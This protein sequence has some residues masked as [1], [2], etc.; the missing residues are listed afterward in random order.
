M[1]QFFRCPSSA[2]KCPPTGSPGTGAGQSRAGQANAPTPR[3]W[4]ESHTF[5]VD[6]GWYFDNNVEEGKP[7]PLLE[8]PESVLKLNMR[9]IDVLIVERPDRGA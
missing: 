4:D 7:V 5:T 3:F 6:G 2:Q 8:A 1:L 9:I